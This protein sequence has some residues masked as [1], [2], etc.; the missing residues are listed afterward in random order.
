M[1]RSLFELQ[2]GCHTM[3]RFTKMGRQWTTSAWGGSLKSITLDSDL[4][5]LLSGSSGYD[6]LVIG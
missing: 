3:V 1:C 4:T 2:P 5:E 6:S